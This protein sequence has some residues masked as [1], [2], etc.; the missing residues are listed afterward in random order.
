M[1]STLAF[2]PSGDE[3]QGAGTDAGDDV[4]LACGLHGRLQDVTGD[5]DA[6][7]E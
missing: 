1:R 4:A 5:A 7:V 3:A 6:A 2:S